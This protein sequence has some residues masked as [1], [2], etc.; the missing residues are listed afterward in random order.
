[1]FDLKTIMGKTSLG[2][3]LLESI[4]QTYHVLINVCTKYN[5]RLMAIQIRNY[6]QINPEA[7]EVI[8]YRGN[9]E[10]VITRRFADNPLFLIQFQRKYMK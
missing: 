10:I 9:K 4:G 3:R 6:F 1:M 8:V 7:I 5:P 2:N